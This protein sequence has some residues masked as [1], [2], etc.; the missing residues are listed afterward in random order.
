ME[1]AEEE[2]EAEA[3]KKRQRRKRGGQD[4]DYCVSGKAKKTMKA[5]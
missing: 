2:E 4:G 5:G 3:E 1:K